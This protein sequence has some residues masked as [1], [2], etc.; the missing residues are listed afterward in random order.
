MQY[1]PNPQNNYPGVYNQT[2]GYFTQG[3]MVPIGYGGYN[4]YYNNYGYYNY[5]PY[6][7]KRQ[8]DAYEQQM[9]EN[10]RQQIDFYKK[11]YK[12]RCNYIGREV[13]QN[14]LA[15]YDSFAVYNTDN[16]DPRIKNLTEAEYAEFSG[17][18]SHEKY[19][20]D[21]QSHVVGLVNNG[22]PY[23]NP[24][25]VYA[26]NHINQVYEQNKAPDDIGLVE[27]MEKY[28]QQQYAAIIDKKIRQQSNT[29]NLYNRDNYNSLLDKHRSELFGGI[30][31]PNASVDDLE[32]RLPNYISDKTKQERRQRFLETIMSQNGG[33]L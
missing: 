24:Y 4:G 21:S 2:P 20:K 33:R 14:E 22:Q 16:T 12:S 9:K 32:V 5:N 3:N 29:G 1:Y 23:V 8:Q 25:T 19:L 10:E 11:L 13:S 27:Y 6:E 18:E 30:L 26:M 15:Y 28:G 7:I 31:D 17:I